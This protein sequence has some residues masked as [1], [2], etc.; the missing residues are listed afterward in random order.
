MRLL[1]PVNTVPIFL[2]VFFPDCRD[3][4]PLHHALDRFLEAYDLSGPEAL[5][6]G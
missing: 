6:T 2:G 1:W 3:E 4:V 5:G